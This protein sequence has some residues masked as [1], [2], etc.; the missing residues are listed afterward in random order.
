MS[1]LK[2][3]PRIDPHSSDSE[4]PKTADSRAPTF[5]MV[6]FRAI[7]EGEI[8]FRKFQK[9]CAVIVIFDFCEKRRTPSSTC[10][11]FQIEILPCISILNVDL[12]QRIPKTPGISRLFA[13]GL[14]ITP[15]PFQSRNGTDVIRV[16]RLRAEIWQ[17]NSLFFSFSR[18]RGPLRS[19]FSIT[20]SPPPGA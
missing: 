17:E 2:K 12:K 13:R 5:Q 18:R 10:P 16:A 19:P 1:S 15:E 6:T 9:S 8:C 3:L 7:F 20:V 11:L 4:I 14:R